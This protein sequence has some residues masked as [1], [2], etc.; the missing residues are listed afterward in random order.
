MP[1]KA[2]TFAARLRRLRERAG[3]TQE[4]LAACLGVTRQAVARWESGTREPSLATAELLAAALGK[5]LRVWEGC[6]CE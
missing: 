4:A 3:L 1:T 6:A 2:E 5:K